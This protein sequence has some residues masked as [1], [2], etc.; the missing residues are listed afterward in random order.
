M[1]Q[2]VSQRNLIG[3]YGLDFR[4]DRVE[5]MVDKAAPEKGFFS[6]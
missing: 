3:M 6:K 1:A 5:F 4:A 2:S